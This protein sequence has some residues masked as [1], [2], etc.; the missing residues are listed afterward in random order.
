[1]CAS[2]IKDAE[3]GWPLPLESPIADTMQKPQTF[4]KIPT[5]NLSKY[6]N[7]KPY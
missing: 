3:M 7:L 1:M 5:I 6:R 2:Q 4:F